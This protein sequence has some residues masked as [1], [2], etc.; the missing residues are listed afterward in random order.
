MD[1][2]L[3]YYWFG[4]KN[5]SKHKQVESS[6][7][8]YDGNMTP[9]NNPYAYTLIAVDK[10]GNESPISNQCTLTLDTTT[11]SK[12]TNLR[13]ETL[14]GKTLACSSYTNQYDIIAKWDSSTDDT[15]IQYYEYQSYNPTTGWIWG[16]PKVTKTERKGA[17]TQGEGTYGFRV[18]AV[19]M[20]GNTSEWTDV[21]FETTCQITY[22]KTAPLAPTLISPSN[23]IVT[24]GDTL[25]NVWSKVDG[26]YTYIY[27][28]YNDSGANSIRYTLETDK[29]SKTATKVQNTTFWWR[30]KA[31]DK[32]GNESPWSPI[33]KITVDNDAPIV[34]ITSHSEGDLVKGIVD[35]KGSIQDSNLW[36]YYYRITGP[37]TDISK[38]IYTSNTFTDQTFYTWDTTK[39][40]D[41]EYEIRLEARDKA[42]NKDT[43]SVKVINV[44]VDNTKPE[45]ESISDYTLYEGEALPLITGNVTDNNEI[46]K[47]CYDVDGYTD[48]ITPTS[49]TSN[50]TVDITDIIS[51]ELG[52]TTADTS[53]VDEG[54]HIIKYYA[55]DTNDNLSDE[56]EFKITILNNSPVLNVSLSSNNVILGEQIS[57]KVEFTD[58]GKDDAPWTYTIKYGDGVTETG[59]VSNTGLINTFLHTYTTANTYNLE[60]EVCES[61]TPGENTCTK[62]NQDITTNPILTDNPAV[63]GVTTTNTRTLS[64]SNTY[65]GGVGGPENTNTETQLTSEDS[66]EEVKGAETCENEKKLFGH[67]YLDT[68][69]NNIYDDKDKIFKDITI[70]IYTNTNEYITEVKSNKD[71]YWETYLCSGEYNIK[72]DKDTL[73]NNYDTEQEVLSVNISD[74]S[75]EASAD[76]KIEDN[77]NFWQKNWVWIILLGTVVVSVGYIFLN[78]NKKGR[79]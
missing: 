70:K 32:A 26:A 14:D 52:I 17:F 4:T 67:V 49:S 58:E 13:Y 2:D 65:T 42:D 71:G 76:S 31:I 24:R 43:N 77:R 38:T 27:Q 79:L 40:P 9:G 60:I 56:K 72:I 64:S 19:D 51:T 3:N 73:P 36:R 29:T 41:G 62:Y 15:G 30:V 1:N 75:T 20:A 74:T 53:V 8:Y 59:S 68:N 63:E 54:E 61:T 23:N 46:S 16:T 50:W 11:P 37:S 33:W 10:A 44:I 18:R 78:S 12:P 45:V 35:I 22:D 55:Q 7:N 47:I 57:A 5:N 34:D 66:N 48:C 28:S 39:N 25:T 21:S 6:K 69:N